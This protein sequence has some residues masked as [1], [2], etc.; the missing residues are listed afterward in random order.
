VQERLAL[1]AAYTGW[2]CVKGGAEE[3]KG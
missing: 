2:V 1:L 3:V